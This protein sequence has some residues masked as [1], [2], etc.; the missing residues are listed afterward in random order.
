MYTFSMATSERMVYATQPS[1]LRHQI[2]A[3]LEQEPTER[4]DG[5]V[6]GVVVP[7]TNRIRGGRVAASVYATLRGR[8]YDT[9]ILVAPSHTGPFSRMNICSVD[10]YRTP[11][12]DLRVNDA[13][14]NEL[15]DEDDDIYLDDQGHYHTEGIDVQLPYLQTV[16]DEFDIVPI[17]MGDESPEY[18][19]ELGA[20]IGEVMYNRKTLLVSTADILEASDEA[21]SQFQ[22]AF[23]ERDVSALMGLLNSER[24]RIEG[25]GPLL[26]ALIAA[27]HR[28]ATHARILRR[29]APENGSPGFVG[30]VLYRQ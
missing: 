1:P 6:L 19:R 30:A 26:V 23:N 20:A 16:L 12:G 27:L 8:A 3:L 17:I 4:I 25:K 14:R 28:R 10:S 21:L 24:L 13:V 15:C 29:E 5:E 2:N 11:L 7:G 18:C 9:V 22:Q